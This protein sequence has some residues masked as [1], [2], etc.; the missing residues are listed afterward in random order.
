MGEKIHTINKNTAV[1][2]AASK[3]FVVDENVYKTK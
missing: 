1:S 3:E 2:L